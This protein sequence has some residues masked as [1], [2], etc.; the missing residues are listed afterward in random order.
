MPRCFSLRLVIVAVPMLLADPSQGAPIT[1]SVEGQLTSVVDAGPY[2]DPSLVP[3]AAFHASFVLES[4]AADGQASDPSLGT[5]G[6]GGVLGPW[7][8][9]AAVGD[10]AFSEPFARLSIHDD[11][12]VRFEG[13]LITGDAMFLGFDFVS[14]P[15]VPCV[16]DATVIVA[17]KCHDFTISFIDPTSNLFG[18][19]V[20]PAAF[21]DLAEWG[22]VTLS[23][24]MASGGAP[25]FSVTGA[26]HAFTAVPEPASAL[27]L[28]CGLVALGA[29]NRSH[30]A[31]SGVPEFR[32]TT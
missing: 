23:M 7:A 24:G 8:S 12:D 4:L 26:V 21:P 16:T 10:Y 22:S 14:F 32:S 19:D 25:G 6:G 20:F 18:S 15:G 27:M 3:G 29:S 13:G 5:Y 9:E 17:G 2:L 31:R 30:T 28:A 11:R 1:I